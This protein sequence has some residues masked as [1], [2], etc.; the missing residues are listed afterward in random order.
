MSTSCSCAPSL[1]R[2]A[3]VAGIQLG[4]AA[5]AQGLLLNTGEVKWPLATQKA[6]LWCEVCTI[7]FSLPQ[8]AVLRVFAVWFS[9][10]KE[11]QKLLWDVNRG[12]R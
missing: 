2:A 9:C 1:C 3:V 10:P 12:G 6:S 5:L 4:S 11:K 8:S 7:G